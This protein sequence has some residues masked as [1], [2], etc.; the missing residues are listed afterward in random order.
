MRCYQTGY[1]RWELLPAAQ[2]R[3]WAG[4]KHWWKKE[5]FHMKPTILARQAGYDVKA[6]EDAA[7]DGQ[8]NQLVA[9]FAPGHTASSGKH[10]KPHRN[11]RRAATSDCSTAG[12]ATERQ[13]R[14][15]GNVCAPRPTVHDEHDTGAIT[16][17]T[18]TGW[19]IRRTRWWTRPRPK[20]QWMT[21]SMGAA[22]AAT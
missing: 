13:Q 4:T 8:C 3:V 14:S 9:H 21:R 6:A 2:K 20:Q 1:D 5:Y 10:C 17:G 12:T 7:E 22:A 15:A 16:S 11:E 18:Q 19:T